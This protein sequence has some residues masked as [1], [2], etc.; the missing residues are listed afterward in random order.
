MEFTRNRFTSSSVYHHDDVVHIGHIEQKSGPFSDDV[1]IK[2]T[3]VHQCRP[4]PIIIDLGLQGCRLGL[5]L[6][7]V[8]Q[9]LGPIFNAELPANGR[10]SQITLKSKQG[11]CQ[12]KGAPDSRTFESGGGHMGE[13]ELNARTLPDKNLTS[14]CETGQVALDQAA[15]AQC[16]PPRRP[17]GQRGNVRLT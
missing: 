16:N 14:R 13:P 1:G 17:I 2:P 3:R 4:M 6:I 8:D 5:E 9:D 7:N 15:P 11:N 12:C 10:E